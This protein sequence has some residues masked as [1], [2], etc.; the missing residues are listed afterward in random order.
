MLN[1]QQNLLKAALHIFAWEFWRAPLL[2]AEGCTCSQN[3]LCLVRNFFFP[4]YSVTERCL[5]L[6]VKELLSRHLYTLKH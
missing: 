4:E 1:K 3:C 2:E 5:G 6:T